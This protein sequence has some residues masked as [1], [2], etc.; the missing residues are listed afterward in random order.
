MSDMMDRMQ[1][2]RPQGRQPSAMEQ[3][4]SPFNADDAA[5]AAQSG[6]LNENTTFGAY[7][8]GQ[9]GIKWEDPLAAAAQ[10]IQQKVK[11]ASPL[12]K[13]EAMAGGAPAGPQV[14]P[15]AGPQAG[16]AQGPGGLDALMQ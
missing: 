7:M 8:E 11:T 3:A 14:R 4:R 13:V 10:K 12:G 2:G 1:A 16:P 15:Q 9:F 6:Q 5:F